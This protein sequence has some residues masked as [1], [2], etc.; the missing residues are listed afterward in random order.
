[1]LNAMYVV[2]GDICLEC[3]HITQEVFMWMVDAATSVALWN[4]IKEIAQSF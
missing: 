3:V 4:I 1:M 2:R